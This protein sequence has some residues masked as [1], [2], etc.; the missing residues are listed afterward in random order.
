MYSASALS[1]PELTA[2]LALTDTT[3]KNADDDTD[4]HMDGQNVGAMASASAIQEHALDLENEAS[5]RMASPEEIAPDADAV[6]NAAHED[7]SSQPSDTNSTAPVETAA[8]I[9]A[10]G[11]MYFVEVMYAIGKI[12]LL[13]FVLTCFCSLPKY[14][15]RALARQSRELQAKTYTRIKAIWRMV[16][17]N[18]SILTR[19]PASFGIQYPEIITEWLR[20][21]ALPVL[22]VSLSMGTECV[23]PGANFYWRLIS[24]TAMPLIMIGALGVYLRFAH[25]REL[26]E[27]VAWACSWMLMISY[28]FLPSCANVIFS[29]FSCEDFEDGSRSLRLDHSISCLDDAYTRMMI[30]SSFV[31]V[32]WMSVPFV[33]G[34]ILFRS[35]YGKDTDHEDPKSKPF[36]FLFSSYRKG[37]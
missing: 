7:A 19:I 36:G 14:R 18:G 24:T 1:D 17:V 16:F 20:W 2:A 8:K 30:Y 22:E 35:F 27:M 10:I 34:F 29:T 32:I 31:G 9:T 28:L 4:G 25:A 23:Y 15:R 26:K 11:A 21:M 12:G 13:V 3:D 33:Y 6:A 37:A 5:E